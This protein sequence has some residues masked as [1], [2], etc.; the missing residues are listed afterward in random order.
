MAFD[1]MDQDTVVEV[2]GALVPVD[3][4][5]GRDIPLTLLFLSV[6]NVRK[7][8]NPETIPMLAATILAQGGLLA[9]LCV[10]PER[11]KGSKVK[12]N[13]FGVVA[14][15]RRLAALLWLVKSGNLAKD[16]LVKCLVFK[17]ERAVSVSLT[18][19]T[20]QE[21]MH[22]AD[23]LEAFKALV[24]EGKTAGEIAASFG[25]SVLTV[26]RRLAL[27]NLAPMFVEM[28]RAGTIKLDQLQALALTS[29][30]EQQLMA[31][32][33]LPSYDRSAYRIRKALTTDELPSTSPLAR[34]VTV[35][36]Y[37]AA[38]GTIREDLFSEDSSIFLQ[39]VGLLNTLAVTRLEAEAQTLR[40]AGWKW[41][42]VRLEFTSSDLS[43]FSRLQCTAQ[44]PLQ[45]EKEAMADLKAD[46]DS[47]LGRMHQLEALAGYNEETEE[48]GELTEAQ[49]AEF[50]ALD[51]QSD[52][53]HDLLTSMDEALRVWKPSQ[54]A[55]SGV[56]IAVG[57]DGSLNVAEGLVRP[58]DKKQIAA[59]G[60]TGAE[61]ADE[62]VSITS[63]SAK[64]RAEYSAALCQ[65]MTAHRTAAV[66]ACLSKSPKVALAALLHTLIATEREPWQRSPLGV[67]FDDH[68]S[69]L[70]RN[71]AEFELT[72]ASVALKNADSVLA[73]LPGD[74][75]ALFAHLQAMDLPGLL[76]LLARSVAHSYSVQSPDPVR[77][78]GLGFD[79]AQ[80]IEAA[81]NVNM[82]EWWNPTMECWLGHV[83]KAK[84]MEAVTESVGAEAARPIEK[85]KKGDA[86]DASASLLEGRSWLPSTLRTYPV[87]AADEEDNIQA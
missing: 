54:R 87:P 38:G 37:R 45:Q 55:A 76:D 5:E 46:L 29:D 53:M 81:L 15:G 52:D 16:A 2:N 12:G 66:A 40:D 71:A 30:H 78:H 14:G 75:A 18:E 39:D 11:L 7:T 63:G 43:R 9:P 23:Q 47:V 34:F 10:V 85:M 31:W 49:Q 61:E 70:L 84:M 24:A 58:E 57:S 77:A 59:A 35:E 25:V 20:Q 64:D 68:T 1:S 79:P 60:R 67:R 19:N 72:P 28:F 3:Q 56:V 4:G 51:E 27:A 8:R 32:E 86:I 83:S 80:G 82:A 44:K 62:G 48:S 69:D 36:A 21:A 50:D 42:E 13:T 65:N 33:S 73:S 74:S 26:E 17:P 41:V 22:P 6:K